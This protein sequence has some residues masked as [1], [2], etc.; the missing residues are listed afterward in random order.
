MGAVDRFRPKR[1]PAANRSGNAGRRPARLSPCTRTRRSSAE[2]GGGGV[3]VNVVRA[4]GLFA[5]AAVF[6]VAVGWL[7]NAEA[8]AQFA[9]ALVVCVGVLIYFFGE[10]LALRGGRARAIGETGHA[11]LHRIV[12]EAAADART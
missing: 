5:G 9:M 3:H 8:G 1:W 10:S 4:V 11:E 12:R 2:R 7:W 6:V